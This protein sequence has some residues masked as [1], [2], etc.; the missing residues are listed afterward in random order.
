M[1][2]SEARQEFDGRYF[3]WGMSEFE[4]EIHQSFSGLKTF[5]SG[6]LWQFRQFMMH[7]EAHEQLTLARACL[8]TAYPDA[9]RALG[10]PLSPEESSMHRKLYAYWR[11]KEIYD[12]LHYHGET[13]ELPEEIFE[14]GYP[15]ATELMGQDWL[16]DRK[17]LY[18][19]LAAEYSR[20]PPSRESVLRAKRAAG[21]QIKFVQKKA[22]RRMVREKAEAAFPNH[23][24]GTVSTD[25]GGELCLSTKICG[26]VVNT[27]FDFGR[28]ET[29][30]AY[31]QNVVSA[32]SHEY[33]GAQVSEVLVPYLIS[34]SG[35]LGI[36]GETKWEYLI[37]DDLQ[38]VSSAAIEFCKRFFEAAPE[39][40]EG[41]EPEKIV[42]EKTA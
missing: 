23:T 28:Q 32:T 16:K 27:F 14:R 31:S 35:W 40:L 6:P 7:L 8:K 1:T 20:I 29:Q 38:T 13:Y 30:L 3:R 2:I 5:E 41:L 19:R 34:F 39:L 18:S 15:E 17:R 11:V 42:P 9:A 4:K 25:G 37:E 10:L 12:L 33:R 26:W 36:T 24:V 21:E 22:L